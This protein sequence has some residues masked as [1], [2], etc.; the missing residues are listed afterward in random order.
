MLRGLA[1][2]I[3]RRGFRLPEYS[4]SRVH[5]L[6]QLRDVLRQLRINCVLDVGA[7]RGQFAGDLRGIGYDG[8]IISFEPLPREYTVLA[9]VFDHDAKW[10]G[11]PVALGDRDGVASMNVVPDLT[12]ISS[13]LRPLH[14][15]NIQT[16]EVKVRRL[17]DLFPALV[18]H[19]AHPRVLLKMDTQGYDLK[20]FAGA[21]GCLNDI[22]ALQSEVSVTPLY[23]GMP[24]YTDALSVYERHGF[25]LIGLSLA[26]RTPA[27]AIEE[28][29]CLMRRQP[30]TR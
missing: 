25:E 5:E 20:V 14:K 27:G 21:T 26:S 7:N 2:R 6:T 16:C 19:I 8:H 9:S 29:N 15:V 10:H 28:L 13:M 11:V 23:A 4:L 18:K 22:V 24:H 17:D 30:E 12:V 1:M 3:V